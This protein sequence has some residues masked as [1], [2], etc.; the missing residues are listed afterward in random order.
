[1]N[2]G[3]TYIIRKHIKFKKNR[4]MKWAIIGT[5]CKTRSLLKSCL[6]IFQDYKIN[7]T[8]ILRK[9]KHYYYYRNLYDQSSYI[10]NYFYFLEII[11]NFIRTGPG[12]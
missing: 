6:R 9:N 7:P 12:Y 3:N 10:E 4:N 1:M 5:S 8:E 11:I 2:Y